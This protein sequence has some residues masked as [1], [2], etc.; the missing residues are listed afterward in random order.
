[1]ATT[2]KKL[3]HKRT[4]NASITSA[5]T[6]QNIEK[7]EIAINMNSGHT[8]LY[9]KRTD[10]TIAEFYDNKYIDE[11]ER[12]TSAAL[13]TLNNTKQDI[14]VSG[15]NIKTVNGESII[16]SGNV[17]TAPLINITYSELKTL[18]DDGKLVPGTQ[19][20]ITD[21]NTTVLGT[22]YTVGGHQFDIIVIADDENTL[23]EVAR[24][25]QHSG[26][27]YFANSNLAAWELKYCLDN[28]TNRFA[29]ADATNGKG[30][31]YYM[32]DEFNNE[33]PYDFKN[34]QFYRKW[35]STKSSWCDDGTSSNGVAAYTFSSTGNSSTT[36]FTDFSLSINNSVYSNVI[37]E[38]VYSKKQKLNN[39]CFF[40]N[41][42]YSNT[43]GDSCY[44]NTFG[45]SIYNNTFGDDCNHITFK[46]SC[47]SNTFGTSCTYNTFGGACQNNVFGNYCADNIFGD[48]CQKNTF[49][50]DCS[51]NA[52][53]DSCSY[54]TFGS[55]CNFNAFGDS[56]SY[57]TFG[58]ICSTNTLGDYCQKNTFSNSCNRNTIGNVCNLNTFGT[59]CQYNIFASN[60][61]G[62]A[63]N[64]FYY[65]KIENGVQYCILYNTSTASSSQLVKNYYIKS[66]VVGTSSS[67]KAIE[68]TRNL[69]YGT[70]VALNSAGALKIYCEADLIN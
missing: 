29:W 54:N 34:I 64:Y 51:H 27:T 6:S 59:D 25:I 9:T 28:D 14:L 23:N 67:E 55:D 40:G 58:N 70:T 13:N 42:C 22:A 3:I 8:R 45:K 47:H 66:S 56:C 1:M 30:V 49:G 61:T 69:S 63:G 46:N 44:S 20:R 31:I 62:T 7:G 65:N 12:V 50:N 33:C 15:T 35:N 39:N 11:I 18:R 17:E 10:D 38:Y 26:D 53:W 32:K 52:F 36:S 43:F 48:Y 68:A 16:G 24:A 4:A 60:S 5:A 37:K 19:Y 41:N 21:Y 57:N 2:G